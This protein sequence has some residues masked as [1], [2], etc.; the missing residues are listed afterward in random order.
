MEKRGSSERRL[1]PGD[2]A[3]DAFGRPSLAVVVPVR[4]KTSALWRRVNH[5][6][7]LGASAAL[8]LATRLSPQPII[9]TF[10][11]DQVTALDG[12]RIER[13]RGDGVTARR[14]DGCRRGRRMP[15]DTGGIR[16]TR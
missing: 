7:A 4:P 10:G 9:F 2:A 14:Q 12:C 11:S 8:S 1:L 15:S 13:E 5:G 3:E 16:R 6:V